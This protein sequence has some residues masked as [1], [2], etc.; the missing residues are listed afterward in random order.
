MTISTDMI[1]Y[2]YSWIQSQIG[3]SDRL[4]TSRTPLHY[5][6]CS[7]VSALKDMIQW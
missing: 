5:L 6:T 4:R 3:A 7:A 1:S 2:C